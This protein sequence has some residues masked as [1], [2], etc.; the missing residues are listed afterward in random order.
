MGACHPKRHSLSD[1][2]GPVNQSGSGFLVAARN[3][4]NTCLGAFGHF[5]YVRIG[6]LPTGSAIPVAYGSTF[7]SYG[8]LTCIFDH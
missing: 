4:L 8:A 6:A 3:T 5:G 1:L 7:G 2:A